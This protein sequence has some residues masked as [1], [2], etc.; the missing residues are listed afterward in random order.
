MKQKDRL[1]IFDMDG[2][3]YRLTGGS[4]RKSRL[5]HKIHENVLKYLQD[6]LGIGKRKSSEIVADIKKRYGENISIGLEKEYGFDRYDYF[7]TVWDVNPEGLIDKFSGLTEIL[8]KLQADYDMILTSDAPLVWIKR[9]LAELGVADIFA[10]KILSGEGDNRKIFG[11]RFEGILQKYNLSPEN[12]VSIG[13]QEETDILPAKSLG[14][15]TIF[16]NQ[17]KRSSYADVSVK[18]LADLVV[19]LD[20]LFDETKQT[21]V[22]NNILDNLGVVDRYKVKWLSGSSSA[23]TFRY[24]DWVYKFGDSDIIT[25]ELDVYRKFKNSLGASFGKIFPDYGI[26][27]DRNGKSLCRIKVVGNINMEDFLLN[28][29]GRTEA[30]IYDVNNKVL[31]GIDLIYNSTCIFRDGDASNFFDELFNAIKKNL[32][33]AGI[34]YDSVFYEKLL[35]NRELFIVPFKSSLSHRDFSVGNIIIDS[36]GD[37]FFIDPKAALP[38]HDQSMSPGNVC[39]D[40]VGYYVSIVRKE[41]E[42]KHKGTFSKYSPIKKSI[43]EKIEKYISAGVIS[44]KLVDLLYMYWYSVYLACNCA[45]CKSVERLWLYKKMEEFF[46]EYKNKVK[47]SL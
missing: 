28:D 11:N 33:A 26:I 40:L 32:E 18:N 22:I 23:L 29:G 44:A 7:N 1:I 24:G 42:G 6:R 5:Q 25:K 15:K 41:L 19:V 46:E 4:F 3:L 8:L 36:A 10:D 16:V 30:E 39:V 12:V 27:Y 31:S 2:T 34:K 13:D 9:V 37:V 21:A 35:A 43:T 45:Y 14:I 47:C 20:Y 17:T 38:Y